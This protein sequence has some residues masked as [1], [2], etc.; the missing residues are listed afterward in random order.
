MRSQNEIARTSHDL[1]TTQER[2]EAMDQAAKDYLLKTANKNTSKAYQD[3]WN[4]WLRYCSKVRIPP[5]EVT[6]GTYS[7]FVAWML[8]QG[9]ATKTIQRRLTGVRVAMKDAGTPIPADVIEAAA[10]TLDRALKQLAEAGHL[11]EPAKAK[12]FTV[13]ELRAM[14][15]AC[16][17]TPAGIRDRALLVVGFAIGARRHELAG[18]HVR[19]MV[20]AAEGLEVL[21]RVSKTGYR[22]VAVPYGQHLS[23]CPVRAWQAWLG[24]SGIGDG[25]AFRRIDRHGRILGSLSPE[26]VGDI[27]TRAAERANLG[28]R[29]AHGLRSGMATEAR[30]GQHDAVTIAAQGGWTPHSREMLGYMQIVDRWTDNPLRGIGM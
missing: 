2:V 6:S 25:P 11:R 3:D 8:G 5:Q 27:V 23:T 24:S 22:D 9:K 13:E 16:P 30:R 10:K 21:V 17:D 20:D 7:G 1:T 15:L 26:G 4:T 14:S 19:N 12:A 18:L 28:H 29:T